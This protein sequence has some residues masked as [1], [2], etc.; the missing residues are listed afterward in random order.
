M[1]ARI[2][3]IACTVVDIALAA[4][5]VPAGIEQQAFLAMVNAANARILAY[6]GLM[7]VARLFD[8]P[9]CRE[10][11]R[12]LVG[13]VR[14]RLAARLLLDRATVMSSTDRRQAFTIGGA[15]VFRILIRWNA[16]RR[17]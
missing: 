7:L 3:S 12:A 17:F 6:G 8:E 5:A 16:G 13:Y 9:R 11:A 2:S 1:A 14:F 4:R 10:L 15:R